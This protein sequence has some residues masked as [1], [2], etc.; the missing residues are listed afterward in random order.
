MTQQDTDNQAGSFKDDLPVENYRTTGSDLDLS[1]IEYD[2]G[3]KKKDAP[4]KVETLP[5]DKRILWPLLIVI[6]MPVA[7]AGLAV[8][9][10]AAA[11]CLAYYGKYESQ[12]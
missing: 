5:L 3:G 7:M 10:V 12:S 11:V 4:K 2:C 9:M 1:D 8:I 6:C